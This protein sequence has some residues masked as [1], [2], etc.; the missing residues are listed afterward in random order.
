MCLA[1]KFSHSALWSEFVI[2]LMEF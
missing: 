2:H 1:G